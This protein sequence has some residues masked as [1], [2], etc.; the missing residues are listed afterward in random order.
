MRKEEKIL[1]R[2][3]EFNTTNPFAGEIIKT[4][5]RIYWRK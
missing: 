4:G 5:E 1:F 3:S 2:K